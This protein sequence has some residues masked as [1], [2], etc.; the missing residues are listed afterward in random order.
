[1]PIRRVGQR[2][3]KSLIRLSVHAHSRTLAI[4]NSYWRVRAVTTIRAERLVETRVAP[5]SGLASTSS[6]VRHRP[7]PSH[8]LHIWLAAADDAVIDSVWCPPGHR[9][10]SV[11]SF[12]ADVVERTRACDDMHHAHAH[13]DPRSAL[14]HPHPVPARGPDSCPRALPGQAPTAFA[15]NVEARSRSIARI[16]GA[17]P[18]GGEHPLL[19]DGV[20]SPS[21]PKLTLADNAPWRRTTASWHCCELKV[22]A[23]SVEKLDLD[24]RLLEVQ[25]QVASRAH[26]TNGF[27]SYVKARW[28][29][30]DRGRSR[31][32]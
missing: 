30:F 21:S 28:R 16:G 17:R 15:L 27:Q 7:V 26:H 13:V 1:M 9:L 12:S 10:R 29:D 3:R 2:T 11:T 8:A 19:A 4:V 5:D 20:N 23:Y 31:P 22:L 14:R 32:R 24:M 6:H 25:V 18:D